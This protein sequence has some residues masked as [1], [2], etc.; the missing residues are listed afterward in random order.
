[1]VICKKITK[2]LIIIQTPL[3]IIGIM[4]PILIRNYFPNYILSTHAMQ[5]LLFAG[6]FKGSVVAVNALWSLK[7]GN[8]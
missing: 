3:S 8:L 6:L 2:I 1:M 4:V 5:I 7:N